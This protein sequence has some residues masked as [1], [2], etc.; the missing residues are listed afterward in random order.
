MMNERLVDDFAMN[1]KNARIL[2]LLG[3]VLAP[4][5][6]FRMYKPILVQSR[7]GYGTKQTSLMIRIK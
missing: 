4:T 1:L 2:G 3:F 5:I 6:I 7:E